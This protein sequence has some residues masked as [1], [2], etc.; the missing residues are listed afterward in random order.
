MS[1]AMLFSD[2]HVHSHK[3]KI[4]RLDDCLKTL[5][6]IFKESKNH[7]CK[8]ILFLGDLFHDRAKID[9]LTYLRTFEAFMNEVDPNQEIYLLVGNHDMYHRER[10]DVNSVKPLTAI[11]NVHIVDEPSTINIGGRNIDWIP[12]TEDPIKEAKKLKEGRDKKDLTLLLGHMAIDNAILNTMYGTKADVIVEY[13]TGMKTVDVSIFDDWSNGRVFLGHYH[14]AQHLNDHVEYLGSPLQLSY[15]EAF[16]EKHIAVLDLKT[17]E[18]EYIINDFSPKHLI[19]EK[20]EINAHNL[21]GNFTRIVCDDMS[22][23]DLIDIKLDL[24]QKHEVAS[25]DFKQ[26]ERKEDEEAEIEEARAILFKHD[27]MLEKWLEEKPVPE[28]LDKGLLLEIGKKI[29]ANQDEE[30]SLLKEL[31]DS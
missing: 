3:G 31:L 9:V 13:D 5:E 21:K 30:G 8:Y 18:Y 12:H 24:M 15:G 2:L 4:D 23:K 17:L 7:E 25:F 26:R 19:L 14:G 6:W 28:G 16:Q 11:P 1:K 10:W 22:A 20:N 29:I 27:E